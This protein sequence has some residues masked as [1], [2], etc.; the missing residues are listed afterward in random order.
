MKKSTKSQAKKPLQ[1]DRIFVTKL[2]GNP[3]LGMSKQYFGVEL[4]GVYIAYGATG[5]QALKAAAQGLANKIAN[6]KKAMEKLNTA[7]KAARVLL[8][9]QEE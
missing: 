6:M 7:R 1:S 9:L 5:E 3:D 2:T 4:N 8:G